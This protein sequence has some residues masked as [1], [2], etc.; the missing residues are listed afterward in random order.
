MGNYF[1]EQL[2][3][4]QPGTN[5][6]SIYLCPRNSA[7]DTQSGLVSITATAVALLFSCRSVS[8]P[9]GHQGPS[10]EANWLCVF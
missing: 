6:Q 3:F 5:T 10:S 1:P 2:E 7:L 4:A 8:F 9:I